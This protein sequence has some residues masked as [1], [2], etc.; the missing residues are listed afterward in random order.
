M[1]LNDMS[2]QLALEELEI[3]ELKNLTK[4]YI[5]KKYYKMALKYHPD[6][7]KDKNA[8]NKFKK[9]VESYEYLIN[10]LNDTE[11]DMLHVNTNINTNSFEPFVSSFSSEETKL[12]TNI[13]TT[14]VTSLLKGSYNEIFTNII[15]EIVVGYNVLTL[16]YLEKIFADLDKQKSI[17]MYNLLNKYKDIFYIKEETL[18]FVSLIIKEKYKNDQIFILRPLLKDLV[19]NNIYKLYVDNELYLVPLWH[20]ELYFDAPDGSEIIVLCQPL[21]PDFI[22]IDENNNIY[23]TKN[24]DTCNELVELI[25]NDGFVSIDVGEKCLSIPISHLYIKKEQLYRL[26]GQG[27]SQISEK[28]MYNVSCKSDIIIKFLLV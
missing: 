8:T 17:D 5:K 15:K 20:N 13:L 11:E 2:L 3:Y 24:I 10:V 19:N 6:K 14:F 12:Y 22:T 16:T 7:N 25:K 9:I 28:D 23:I 18:E 1:E 27:I 4:D 21:L 26:K